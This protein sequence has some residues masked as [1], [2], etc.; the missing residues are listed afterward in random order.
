MFTGRVVF[1]LVALTGVVVGPLILVGAA[2]PKAQQQPALNAPKAVVS[3]KRG[4]TKEVQL[5]WDDGTGR[6]ERLF[7]GADPVL[8]DEKK[9]DQTTSATRFE[10]A[11]LTAQWDEKQ[12]AAVQVEYCTTGQFAESQKKGPYRHIKVVVVRVTAAKDAE[13][14][15]RS[16]FI[17]IVSGTAGAGMA[18]GM[19]LQ[20]EFRVLVRE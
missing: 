20:G 2:A 4:E 6:S 9:K 10:R 12:S 18:Q 19:L 5:C 15:A 11:G 17:H 14:G 8:P 3:L 7:L 13:L 1:A 16:V